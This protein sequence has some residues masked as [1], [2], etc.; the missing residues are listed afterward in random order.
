MQISQLNSMPDV[1][2]YFWE[3]DDDHDGQIAA[4]RDE[5][6]PV[7]DAD[8]DSYVSPWEIMSYVNSQGPIPV[9]D[10]ATVASVRQINQDGRCFDPVFIENNTL[11]QGR[12]F[13]G[14]TTLYFHDNGA[15]SSGSLASNASVGFAI[16]K[17]GLATFHPN[18]NIESATLAFNHN[19]PC[20]SADGIIDIT[21]TAVFA[22]GKTVFFYDDER[23]YSG[24]L[25]SDAEI[26][27]VRFAGGAALTLYNNGKVK[28]GT[29]AQ[30]LERQN[31]FIREGSRIGFGENGMINYLSSVEDIEI[32]SIEF[33]ADRPIGFYANGR[34]YEG[35]L[36][37]MEVIDGHSFFAGTMLT[38]YENGNVRT[39]MLPCM[40][41]IGEHHFL[42]NTKVWF[43]EDGGLSSGVE[44]PG[45]SVSHF[46][47]AG[48]V[49]ST[50]PIMFEF[51]F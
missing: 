32:G 17:A 2:N 26:D 1:I 33:Q 4:F 34:M 49:T 23:I 10:Q 22:A 44:L 45:Y 6:F 8:G 36:A 3:R 11:I 48:N 35:T 43:R 40:T 16:L 21:D 9:F 31:M 37:D 5:D 38:F 7:T 15:V 42:E 51:P 30:D 13:S 20:G 19:C 24:T 12:M 18:G 41:E 50:S 28:E 14:Q 39:A 29:L 47:A 25:V 27:D 46:D